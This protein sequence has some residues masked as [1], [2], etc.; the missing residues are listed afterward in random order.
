MNQLFMNFANSK[1]THSGDTST[2]LTVTHTPFLTL[3]SLSAWGR[4][5]SSVVSTPYLE[6]F[7]I[8]TPL[9][10]SLSLDQFKLHIHPHSKSLHIK[11]QTHFDEISYSIAI[12]L[13]ITIQTGSKN[14][15]NI[16][17][18]IRTDVT[19]LSLLTPSQSISVPVSLSLSLSPQTS[20]SSELLNKFCS[21]VNSY[22]IN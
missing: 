9:F 7:T 13:K 22:S 16:T 21:Y 19:I 1:V 8:F 15:P 3:Y 11:T 5:E 6:V 10:L 4:R 18:A 12:A 20:L 2:W 14:I 17:V